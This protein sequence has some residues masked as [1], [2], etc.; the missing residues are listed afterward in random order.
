MARET[1]ALP[2]RWQRPASLVGTV[3]HRPFP[4]LPDEEGMARE[5]RALPGRWPASLVGPVSHRPLPRLLDRDRSLSGSAL[6]RSVSAVVHVPTD[7]ALSEKSPDLEGVWV[8][9]CFYGQIALFPLI[10]GGSLVTHS[11]V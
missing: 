9:W 2:E 4:R 10:G 5:T 8:R 7:A 11:D 6:G 1:R 3:S